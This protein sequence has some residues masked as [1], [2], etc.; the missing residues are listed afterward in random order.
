MWQRVLKNTRYYGVL[1]E[2]YR[3]N[4]WVYLLAATG[5]VNKPTRIASFTV[6]SLKKKK[7]S[8]FFPLINGR[9]TK[10]IQNLYSCKIYNTN[11]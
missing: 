11:T 6:S 7:E 3:L 4:S 1:Y 5:I 8:N 10:K 9:R 2:T